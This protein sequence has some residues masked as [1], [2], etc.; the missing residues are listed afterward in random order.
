MNKQLKETYKSVK[1]KGR[2][3]GEKNTRKLD[4]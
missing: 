2:Y 1:Q 4:N 3:I